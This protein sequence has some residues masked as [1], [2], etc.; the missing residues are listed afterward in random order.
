MK[1]LFEEIMTENF[2]KL[3]KEKDT[4]V[5]EMQRGPNKKVPKRPTSRHIIIKMSK[6]KCWWEGWVG[7]VGRM[8]QKK[9]KKRKSLW[10]QTIV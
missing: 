8:E 9:K 3:V 4:Q 6:V 5:Q 10:T 7:G 1:N 2:S